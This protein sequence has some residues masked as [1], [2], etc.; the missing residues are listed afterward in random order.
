MKDYLNMS[1]AELIAEIIRLKKELAIVT[2]EV[3]LLNAEVNDFDRKLKAANNM[4]YE[5]RI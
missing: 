1:K 5:R 2:E 3:W 4:Q